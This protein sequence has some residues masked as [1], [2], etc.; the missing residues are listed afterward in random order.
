MDDN[1]VGFTAE[2]MSFY[3]IVEIDIDLDINHYF[4]NT[5]PQ[6]FT[7]NTE[8]EDMEGVKMPIMRTEVFKRKGK[9]IPPEAIGL[10]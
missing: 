6:I 7:L 2:S 8:I 3:R 1:M 5:P 9:I 4:K 10:K